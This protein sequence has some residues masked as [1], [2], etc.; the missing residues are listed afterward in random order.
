MNRSDPIIPIGD[1]PTHEIG[2]AIRGGSAIALAVTVL[3]LIAI[4]ASAL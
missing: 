1:R 4:L 3:L 2:G